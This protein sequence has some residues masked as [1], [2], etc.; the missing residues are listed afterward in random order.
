MGM[1]F[2]PSELWGQCLGSG[3]LSE[4]PS[5]FP[6]RGLNKLNRTP[7]QTEAASLL[8]PS[9]SKFTRTEAES[10]IECPWIKH[11]FNV[12]PMMIINW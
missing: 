1:I 7:P 3:A 2:R 9:Q 8:P 11:E 4:G 12:K 6:H 10:M 5:D